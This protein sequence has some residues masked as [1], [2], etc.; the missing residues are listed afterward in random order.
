MDRVFVA[1]AEVEGAR[2]QAVARVV[3]ELEGL[4]AYEAQEVLRLAMQA[5]QERATLAVTAPA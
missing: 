2:G 4:S 5:A 1:G 3:H